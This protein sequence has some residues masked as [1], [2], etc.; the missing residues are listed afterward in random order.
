MLALPLMVAATLPAMEAARLARDQ[1]R[2][3]IHKSN[4]DAQVAE[5][6]AAGKHS[7]VVDDWST[8][9]TDNTFIVWDEWDKPEE[10]M[11]FKPYHS[12]GGHYYKV[13]D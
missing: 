5:A 6:K 13:G 1:A 8:F 7:I 4:Y 3:Y 2:F 10:A 11:G 9:V 12:F